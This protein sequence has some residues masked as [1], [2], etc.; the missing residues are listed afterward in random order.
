[1]SF[2]VVPQ[3]EVPDF[4]AALQDG[5]CVTCYGPRRPEHES[6]YCCACDDGCDC[7]PAPS[8]DG[9]KADG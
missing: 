5:R 9:G 6:S 4:L 8:V 2:R 1:V 3:D 7:Q